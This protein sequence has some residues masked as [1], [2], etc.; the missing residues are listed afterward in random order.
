MLYKRSLSKNEQSNENNSEKVVSKSHLFLQI[1][2]RVV[3]NPYTCRHMCG[4]FREKQHMNKCMKKHITDEATIL[5]VQITITVIQ[6]RNYK[7]VIGRAHCA[8]YTTVKE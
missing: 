3:F 2:F 8:S 6:N 5:Y 4:I 1:L 7:T